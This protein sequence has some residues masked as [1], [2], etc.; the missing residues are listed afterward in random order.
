MSEPI[1][2]KD[3]P[4]GDYFEG[5]PTPHDSE[6]MRLMSIGTGTFDVS[7]WGIT[8]EPPTPTSSHSSDF[9][10]IPTSFAPRN[11]HRK[12]FSSKSLLPL[13]T[14][15]PPSRTTKFYNLFTVVP[16]GARLM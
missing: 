10:R 7:D 15:A 3:T 1:V 11:L 9:E 13:M 4:L 8:S 16:T 14:C 6:N 12:R 2:Y 5:I